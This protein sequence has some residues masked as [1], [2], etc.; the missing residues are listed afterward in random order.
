MSMDLSG[1][2]ALVTGGCQGIGKAVALRLA[3][4]GADVAIV[5]IT[6]ERAEEGAA[7]VRELGRKAL[8]LGAD[9]SDFSAA[10]QAVQQT[11]KELGGLQILVNNAGITRDG[12]FLR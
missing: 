11:L 1:K 9:V 3:E 4:A 5:D 6:E 10:D 7:A 2:V 12:L 8:A